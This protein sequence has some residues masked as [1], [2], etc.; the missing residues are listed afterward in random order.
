M[1]SYPNVWPGLHAS[2]KAPKPD[3]PG[4]L[5]G[6]TRLLGGFMEFKGSNVGKLWAINGNHGN[7]YIF[8][9][10]GLFVATLFDDMRI[11]QRWTMPVAKRGMSLEGITLNDENFWPTITQTADGQVYLVDGGRS[12]LVRL[13]GIE[14]IHRLKDISLSVT[15]DDLERSRAWLLKTEA[16]RQKSLGSAVLNIAITATAPVVDGK[17]DDWASAAWADIDKRGVKAYFNANS[18]PYDI[19]GALT[20]AGERLYLAYRTGDDKLLKNSGEMPIAPFKTGGALDLMIG[21]NREAKSER[22]EP[23]SGDTRIL[24]TFVDGKLEFERRKR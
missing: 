14:N 15:T 12:A 9:S 20:V 3:H 18:K 16:L 19:T 1:W 5:I 24:V 8:T 2:H 21:T 7:V 11:G 23:V 13:D 17:M 22:Q 4:E 10:D 6:P